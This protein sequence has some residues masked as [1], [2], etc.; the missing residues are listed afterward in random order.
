MKM[1]VGMLADLEQASKDLGKSKAAI[2]RDV[3]A[4]WL[5]AR[6]EAF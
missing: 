3:L 6:R 1:D 4:N 2:V 5:A